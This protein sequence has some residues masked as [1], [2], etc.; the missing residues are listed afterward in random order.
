MYLLKSPGKKCSISRAR[1]MY[2]SK[3]TAKEPPPSWFP[4]QNPI[5]RE[6]PSPEHSFTCLSETPGKDL[7]SQF[8]DGAPM[9]RNS[10]SQSHR[11]LNISWSPHLRS[12]RAAQVETNMVTVCRAP[13]RRDGRPTYNEVQL[14]SPRG[15]FTTLLFT[16]PV[17]CSLQ[18]DTF[19]RGLGRPEPRQPA[20]VHVTPYRVSPRHLLSSP[21]WPR[22]QM[23]ACVRVA[24]ISAPPETC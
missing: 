20:C 6:A 2:L 11:E 8:P 14:G 23:P 17:P 4:S 18:H 19:P 9:A 22:V 1:F 13:H 10:H 16:T 5:E 12:C 21:T 7:P 24:P 3:S 15:L